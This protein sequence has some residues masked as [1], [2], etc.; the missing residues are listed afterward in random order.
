MPRDGPLDQKRE[1][2]PVRR[3]FHKGI[4]FN[5]FFIA[6]CHISKLTERIKTDPHRHDQFQ[7]RK[8]GLKDPVHILNKKVAV[9]IIRQ[10]PNVENQYGGKQRFF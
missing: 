4:R 8:I 1:E 7:Q 9:F 2:Q 6:V 5:L 3:I 10:R